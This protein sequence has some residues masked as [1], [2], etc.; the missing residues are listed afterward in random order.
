[1]KNQQQ[2]PNRSASSRHKSASPTATK[3]PVKIKNLIS[4]Y[5]SSKNQALALAFAFA[6]TTVLK[7]KLPVSVVF[8]NENRRRWWRVFK[9]HVKPK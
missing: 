5:L 1:I 8:V 9:Q 3:D 7:L 2:R 6:S 4:R